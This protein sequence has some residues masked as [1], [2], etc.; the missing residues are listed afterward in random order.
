MKN[1]RR[2]KAPNC[3]GGCLLAKAFGVSAANSGERTRR[4]RFQRVN[5]GAHAPRVFGDGTLAIANFFEID[6][7]LSLLTM[8]SESAEFAVADTFLNGG[9]AI[10]RRVTFMF[11]TIP[12]RSSVVSGSIQSNQWMNGNLHVK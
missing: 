7:R 4:W 9:L 3:R 5:W 11:P 10:M 6:R 12:E 1:Q 8:L 2:F